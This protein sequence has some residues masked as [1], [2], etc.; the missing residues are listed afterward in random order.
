VPADLRP[1]FAAHGLDR[2]VDA[3]THSYEVGAEKP[4]PAI[5]LAAARS[6]GVAPEETLMVGDHPV[7][8]E[9]ERVGM[10]VLMLP[11]E[12]D[13]EMRGLDRV[14]ALIE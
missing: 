8:A 12:F 4:A 5:F 2:L 3:F 6:L 1:I 10:R 7:D 13:R 9:A 11:E 14:L